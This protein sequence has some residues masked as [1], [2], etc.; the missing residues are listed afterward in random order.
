MTQGYAYDHA[1]TMERVRLA[2]LELALDP[3]TREH[4][5]RL[6]VGPGTRC[7]EIGAGGGSVACWL[8]ERVAPGGM[9]VATD[10]ETDFLESQA[11]GYTTLEVLRHDITAEELPTGFDVVHTRWLVEWLPD[12]RLALRRMVAALR[13]GGVLLIEEPDFVTIYESGDSLAVRH[14]YV[15]AMRH[16]ESTCPVE[17][18]YGRRAMGDLAAVGLEDVHAEGR[19][20]IVRGG[21]PLAADFLR[22]TLEKL[23]EPVLAG[24]AVTAE[25][26]AEAVAALQ[27]PNITVVAP[28]T[29]AAWGRRP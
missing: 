16:L 13:P 21:T 18:E 26:F 17:C 27:D 2:A 28:M 20:P 19:C 22:L 10:L 15:A 8:A 9:V 24:R 6:G 12:K 11:Q 5:T 25:E 23:R 1:W 3:G 7:L 14:V 29:V 4:L